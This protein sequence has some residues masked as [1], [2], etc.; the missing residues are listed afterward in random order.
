MNRLH[1]ALYGVVSP[2]VRNPLRKPVPMGT[3]RGERRSKRLPLHVAELKSAGFG[4]VEGG[5]RETN[6][7]AAFL[8]SNRSR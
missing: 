2:D 6:V 3:L 5:T 4:S 8:L 1:G 7:P